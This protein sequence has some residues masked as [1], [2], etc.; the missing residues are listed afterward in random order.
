MA[1]PDPAFVGPSSNLQCSYQLVGCCQAG[2]YRCGQRY[3]APPGSVAPTSNDQA[4]FGEFPWQVAILSSGDVYL[5]SG[6]LVTEQHVL[7]VAHK[8]QKIP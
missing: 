7:T 4:Y 6:A 8:V 5:G 3:P 2:S 1:P